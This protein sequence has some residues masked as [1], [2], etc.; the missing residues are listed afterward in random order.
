[1]S[2][3]SKLGHQIGHAADRLEHEVADLLDHLSESAKPVWHAARELT[4]LTL[5]ELANLIAAEL[6][7]R[8]ED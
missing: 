6:A 5:K 8:L 3:L 4:T 7:R 1:M 2:E